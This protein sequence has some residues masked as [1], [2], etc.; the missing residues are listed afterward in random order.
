MEKRNEIFASGTLAYASDWRFNQ[1]IYKRMQR[2][3]V[4]QETNYKAV[5]RLLNGCI[6]QATW[7]FTFSWLKQHL[8]EVSSLYS[9]AWGKRF[10]CKGD[11]KF[12]FYRTYTHTKKGLFVVGHRGVGWSQRERGAFLTLCHKYLRDG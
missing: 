3:S 1:N 2:F 12:L 8:I 5:L 4:P 10:E 7:K 9:S 11:Q 6:L